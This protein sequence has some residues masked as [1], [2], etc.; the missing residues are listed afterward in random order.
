MYDLLAKQLLQLEKIED[1]T[2]QL[3]NGLLNAYQEISVDFYKLHNQ[4]NSVEA[5]TIA[6][7]MYQINF[8]EILA[9]L[10][11]KKNKS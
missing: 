11:E 1:I 8:E 7:E 3:I 10:I 4:V 9:I 6:R 2:P 5:L